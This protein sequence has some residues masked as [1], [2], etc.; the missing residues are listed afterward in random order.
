MSG[1]RNE[2]ERNCANKRLLTS[3]MVHIYVS[4]ENTHWTLHERLL[5]YFSP[6]FRR[7]FYSKDNE[8]SSTKAFGLPETDDAPF[9]LFVG[10]LYSRAIRP[11]STEKEIGSLLDLYFLAQTLEIEKLE[12]EVVDVVRTYYHSE[13]TYPGLRRVQYVYANTSE[14]NEMREM[15]VGAVARYLTLGDA[16][17]AHWENAL[18]R[19]GQ[20]SLDIIRSIQH[21]NLEGRAVPDVRDMS[22]DRG[23]AKTGFSAISEGNRHDSIKEED[24]EDEEEADGSPK[25]EE[26]ES[27]AGV[28][29]D[30]A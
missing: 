6:F 24:E 1:S 13:E 10:W 27:H 20:L 15:M 28:N 21:W 19:N 25:P 17:P 16:I 5:C 29:G 12:S 18:K 8:S 26:E 23:R 14:D 7:V 3:S 30:S 4:E 9:E 2:D 11:P 22:Q